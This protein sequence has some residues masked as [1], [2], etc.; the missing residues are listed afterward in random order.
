[1]TNR[2]RNRASLL[3]MSWVS[4]FPS[5]LRLPVPRPNSVNGMTAMEARRETAFPVLAKTPD[6]AAAG[7][8]EATRIAAHAARTGAKSMPSDA[9]LRA[10]AST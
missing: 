4:A 6:A 1:M 3:M 8:V 10:A 2:L 5:T 7:A 9:K